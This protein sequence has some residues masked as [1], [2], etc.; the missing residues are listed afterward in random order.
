MRSY[1]RVEVKNGVAVGVFSRNDDDDAEYGVSCWP[2]AVEAKR[3]VST[4]FVVCMEVI[5]AGF[6]LENAATVFCETAMATA[7]PMDTL[8]ENFMVLEDCDDEGRLQ[9]V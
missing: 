9:Q 3:R 7:K 8:L 5:A 1:K 2:A 6:V 4:W